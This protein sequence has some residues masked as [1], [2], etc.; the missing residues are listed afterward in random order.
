METG[1]E[2][3]HGSY[4]PSGKAARWK[5][6]GAAHFHGVKPGAPRERCELAAGPELCVPPRARAEPTSDAPLGGPHAEATQLAENHTA[7]RH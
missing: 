1:E 4:E 3:L 6:D 2:R 5:E 7:S